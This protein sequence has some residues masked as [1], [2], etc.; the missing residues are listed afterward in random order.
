MLREALIAEAQSVVDEGTAS[1]SDVDV[2]IKSAM[3]FPKGPIQWR[4]ESMAA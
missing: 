2:A 1:A 3:N 4:K